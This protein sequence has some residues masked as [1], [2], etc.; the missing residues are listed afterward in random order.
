MGYTQQL[1][2]TVDNVQL[3]STIR[4]PPPLSPPVFLLSSPISSTQWV[5]LSLVSSQASSARRKCVR[6]HRS[7]YRASLTWAFRSGILMVTFFFPL[8]CS[9]AISHTGIG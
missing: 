9:P 1:K 7:N 5:S 6:L 8:V 2:R 4:S 3:S